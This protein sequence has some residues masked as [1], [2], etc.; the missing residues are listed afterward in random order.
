MLTTALSANTAY[1]FEVDGVR[2][3]P[4]ENNTCKVVSKSEFGGSSLYEGDIVIPSTVQH[5]GKVFTVVAIG[6]KAFFQASKLRNIKF[7]KTLEVIGE[8]AFRDATSLSDVVFNDKI[9]TI[10]AQAF[11]NCQNL[12]DITIPASVVEIGSGAFKE[13][14]AL[15]SVIISDSSQ[16]ITIKYS[17]PQ[18]GMTYLY[19]GRE[20]DLGGVDGVSSPFTDC[21]SLEHVEIGKNITMLPSIFF[22]GCKNLKEILIPDWI[23]SIGS[24]CFSDCVSL[25]KI[26][27]GNGIKEIP[28]NAFKDCKSI[29]SL[30]LGE[31]IVTIRESA[32]DLYDSGSNLGAKQIIFP[33]SLE[34]IEK[35][36][37][38]R[39]ENLESIH[40]GYNV[41]KLGQFS[42]IS[43]SGLKEII[44]DAINPPQEIN[45]S[46]DSPSVF[47]TNSDTY[48]TATLFVPESSLDS[49]RS[50]QIWRFFKNIM[51]TKGDSGI[52]DITFEQNSSAL[53]EIYDIRGSKIANT[54][55]QLP[56]GMYIIRQGNVTKKVYVK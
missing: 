24:A 37:F 48:N 20:V 28:V 26:T 8:R 43:S 46:W 29:K 40:L 47:G 21:S 41:K 44:C 10:G 1:Y 27:I 42:F 52:E 22:S 50:S 18:S 23:M 3:S 17:F 36:A 33:E 12:S 25:E 9:Q 11:Y 5:E 34:T 14:K 32:F 31:N 6:D 15:G 38:A 16:P 19:L 35:F 7:P 39:W 51:P 56:S 53:L 55:N 13:C 4:I 45:G 54:K 30:N 49:Y 2:Y